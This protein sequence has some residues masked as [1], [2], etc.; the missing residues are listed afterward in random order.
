MLRT[1]FQASDKEI[2]KARLYVTAR[3]IYEIYMN[4]KRIGTDYFN[5]GLTQYNITHMYQTYDVTS[6]VIPQGKNAIGALLGEGWWS[7]NI[8]YTGSNWNYFGDR[9]SLL[10]KLVITYE[11]GS[12]TVITTN[13]HDWKYYNKGPVVYGSFFQGEFY[14]AAREASIK[15]WDVADFNDQ[16]WTD[17]VE[18]PLKGSSFE[19]NVGS[20]QG[21]TVSFNFDKMSLIGQ[22]GE[23]AAMVKE[24]TAVKVEEVR[25][26]IFVYDMGQNM[27]GVPLIRLDGEKAGT[28]I[29]LRYAEMKY[30]DLSEYEQNTG[31]IMIENIRAAPVSPCH[32]RF[33]NSMVILHCWK[34]IIMQWLHI[35]AILRQRWIK[36]ADSAQIRS[37]ET[38][39]VLR[40][41]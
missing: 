34:S 16:S 23:N 29:T 30:P 14:D 2:K 12:E 9:Q 22:I 17:A 32:G 13:D 28:R 24:L 7:G 1:E 10:A 4:G 8:T 41:V 37:W 35:S 20:R 21:G 31:M 27:V 40:I 11:D 39:S 15:G 36:I 18:I 6:S 19:G 3:G 26:G 5:P 33:I 25:P 38:G